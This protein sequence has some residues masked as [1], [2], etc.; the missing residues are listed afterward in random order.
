VRAQISWS[1]QDYRQLV[2]ASAPNN[3]PSGTRIT[4]ANWA[5][6]KSFLPVGLRAALSDAYQFHVTADPEYAMVVAPD[7]AFRDTQRNG[8]NICSR[9]VWERA[10]F[11]RSGQGGHHL[12]VPSWRFGGMRC[13]GNLNV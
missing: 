5:Q 9:R 8:S 10:R 6:Y 4:V 13:I 11:L 12:H 2:D 7:H 3:I 1:E